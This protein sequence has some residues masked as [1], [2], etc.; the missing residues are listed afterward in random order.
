MDIL[1]TL[2][3]QMSNCPFCRISKKKKSHQVRDKFNTYP[4]RCSTKGLLKKIKKTYR[5]H[6]RINSNQIN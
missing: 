4:G 5:L 2:G 3:W 1:K 6:K